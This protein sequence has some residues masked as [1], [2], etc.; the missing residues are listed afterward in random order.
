MSF[1]LRVISILSLMVV[2]GFSCI[3][4]PSS[5]PRGKSRMGKDQAK[6]SA[7]QN[8][9]K[10]FFT[11]FVVVCLVFKQNIGHFEITVLYDAYDVT[12]MKKILALKMV[13]VTLSNEV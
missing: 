11:V 6:L 3:L 10:V 2:F 13:R 7:T 4:F 8:V 1:A 9:K 12:I 5:I